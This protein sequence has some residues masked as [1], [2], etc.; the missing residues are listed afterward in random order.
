MKLD[1]IRHAYFLGIGGIG[2]SA[3]ARYFL[4][5][6]IEVSGYD[7]TETP[8]TR[9]LESEG[10]HIHYTDLGEEVF[11]RV[12]D[13]AS[14]LVVITPAIPQTHQEWHYLKKAGYTILKRAQVLGI[15]S[16]S[17]LTLG[18]AGTHGKTTTS[19][20]LAHLL[21]QSN[22]DG[23]AF[24]GGISTNY[25]SNLLLSNKSKY[26][27]VEADEFDRS[28]LTLHPYMSVITST[29]ADHLDIYGQHDA[30]KQSFKDYANLTKHL[31]LIK[32]ELELA[33][34]LKSEKKAYKVF[35]YSASNQ[36]DYYADEITIQNGNYQFNIHTPSLTI[37]NIELGIAGRHNVE[38]AVA[39]AAI[40]LQC[41]V[42]VEELRQGL[43]SF[44]GVKRRFE[45]C[46]KSNN[47][48]YIDDYAHHPEELRAIISSVKEMYPNKKLT[49]IFQP[50]LYTRTRDFAAGFAES[51][52]LA[53]ELL[54]LDIYPARELPIEGVTS[55]IIFKN[56]SIADKTALPM[57]ETL[58]WI[59]NK[60]PELLLTV[61]AGDIDTLVLP[62]TLLLKTL[63]GVE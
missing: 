55:G 54:L 19:T 38:N 50:H 24:L 48:T 36:A 16:E 59:E 18:I 1:H 32:Y 44:H 46:I 34:E 49:V 40:A 61:G 52:S 15:I 13:K 41:G 27:T 23:S 33:N 4:H 28:F 9:D 22:V 21:K 29:D 2:M 5:A 30:L 37:N 7:R 58:K 12:T 62:I 43:K 63:N 35:T 51:L 10:M 42:K 25:N 45:Y 56:I 20:M 8:L 47:V 17:H 3:I 60:K 11:K 31:L 26:I 6:G 53:D 57:K 39:A 14:T